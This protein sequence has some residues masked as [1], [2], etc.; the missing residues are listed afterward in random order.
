[1]Y[2]ILIVFLAIF[3]F[4]QT[5]KLFSALSYYSQALIHI[6][7]QELLCE[8][9]ANSSGW[10]ARSG[11][12]GSKDLIILPEWFPKCV[13]LT[14]MPC[15]SA[16]SAHSVWARLCWSLN[17]SEPDV[18]LCCAFVPTHASGVALCTE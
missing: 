14:H 5:C 15:S 16:C 17:P 8:L 6:D 10:L 2:I 3:F 11:I 9:S 7:T 13:G 18:Y 12:N 1:L 4:W